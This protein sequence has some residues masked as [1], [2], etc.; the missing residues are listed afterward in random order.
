VRP[1]F[2]AGCLFRLEGPIAVDFT[3]LVGAFD[4]PFEQA[5]NAPRVD[6]GN[7]RRGFAEDGVADASVVK[8]EVA[9]GWRDWAADG[10][11][12]DIDVEGTPVFGQFA[13]PSRVGYADDLIEGGF[14]RVESPL[15]EIPF[16]PANVKP[17]T[18][19]HGKAVGAENDGEAGV[20]EA[21]LKCVVGASPFAFAE[22]IGGDSFRK[23]EE[24][25]GLVGDVGAEIHQHATAGGGVLFPE[26][27]RG[28]AG[29]PAVE[30][31]LE[32]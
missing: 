25:Q 29:T 9:E 7:R 19:G 12:L 32:V 8:A 30:A 24:M 3:A 18:R 31:R 6:R 28:R 1:F 23:A 13:A 21:Q 27:V 15:P 20:T 16:G 22:N 26:A 10:T 4:G 11:S 2:A 5:R 17:R 14:L